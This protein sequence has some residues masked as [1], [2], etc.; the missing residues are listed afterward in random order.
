[1]IKWRVE[2]GNGG[3]CVPSTSKM[4]GSESS[5]AISV[6]SSIRVVLPTS[7]AKENV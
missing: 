1:M 7:D 5:S 6:S 3:E 4:N 2:S